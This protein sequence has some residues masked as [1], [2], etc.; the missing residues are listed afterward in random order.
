[1]QLI[2][3]SAA[4][5]GF[6]ERQKGA[7]YITVDTEFMRE[8]TYWPILCLVQVAGLEEAVAI[9][10]LVPGI[11][12]QP[13]LALM[14]DSAILKVF[15]AARQDLEIFCHLSGVVPEPLF[16]TQVAAMVCGFGDSVSYETLVR[17]LAGTGLDKASRF[18]DWSHR[19][20]TERQIKYALED[21]VHLRTVYERMQQRLA[22]NGRATWFSEEMAALAD[23][24][25]Y[26]TEPA[27]AWHRFRLRGRADSRFLGVLRALAAWREAAA[28]Q[29]DLPRQRILRDEALLEIAAHAPRS[30]ET[31][32]RTRSLGK[33]I[34]EGRLGNEILQAVA[35][36]LADPDPPPAVAQKAQNPPGLGPLIELLR[37]LLKQRCEDFEVAQ[38]LVASAD[39]L[40]A[41]AADDNADVPAL[42]GWRREVFGADALALKHGTL[43]LTAGRNRIELVPLPEPHS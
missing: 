7:D 18:T 2:T 38:K 30:I 15:H 36:G 43:A 9:D 1:M 17:K 29:R 12:L 20:L 13:L 40:E 11:D 28:Q 5:A 6:C 3:D 14:A 16:D 34:A 10:A 39:D 4:L 23:A 33:G 32:A 41:V 22:K 21:V 24:T 26:R 35:A 27:E 25:L 31:L 19:P 8:R 42:Y 37:V